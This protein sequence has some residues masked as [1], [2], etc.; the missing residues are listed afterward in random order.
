VT[1][2]KVDWSELRQL[3][4]SRLPARLAGLVSELGAETAGGTGDA[5]LRQ[6]LDADTETRPALLEGYIRDHLARAIGASPSR[7]DPHQSLLSL[8]LDSLIA[9]EVR[10]RIN[11]DFGLNVPLAKIIQ[12]ASVHA[13]AD[14]LAGRLAEQ[15]GDETAG[16][17]RRPAPTSPAAVD[18][19]GTATAHG[20]DSSPPERAAA[21]YRLGRR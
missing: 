9:V 11:S 10:N 6:I 13:L 5:R 14:Y 2:A 17:D 16:A 18:E 12:S 19:A 4:G 1:L 8:G 15:D 7:I 21:E 20:P 3:A